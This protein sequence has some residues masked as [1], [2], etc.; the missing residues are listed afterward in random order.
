VQKIDKA[1]ADFFLKVTSTKLNKSILIFDHNFLHSGTTYADF[2]HDFLYS[3]TSLLM[4]R[5]L[6]SVCCV[7]A[8]VCVR[9]ITVQRNNL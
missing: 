6:Q 9:T 8:C 4:A 1:E 2:N 3:G 5:V 7:R